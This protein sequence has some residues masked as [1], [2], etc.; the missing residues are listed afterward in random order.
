MLPC[1]GGNQADTLLFLCIRRV[2]WM[3]K[4]SL[5]L[6]FASCIRAM[7]ARTRR[8]EFCTVMSFLVRSQVFHRELQL[9][10]VLREYCGAAGGVVL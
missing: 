3:E 4:L 10:S 9:P 6:F 8:V 7:L 1:F 5:V 2:P